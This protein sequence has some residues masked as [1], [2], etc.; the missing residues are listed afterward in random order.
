MPMYTY[1][2]PTDQTE[3]EV[4]HSMSANPAID[5]PECSGR[6]HRVISGSIG[7]FAKGDGA[8][9][10]DYNGKNANHAKYSKKHGAK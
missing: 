3:L 7:G 4:F 5:C 2:C 6:M 10:K 9:A 8:Y 1:Q